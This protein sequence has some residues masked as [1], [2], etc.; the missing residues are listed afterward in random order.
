MAGYCSTP[1]AKKLGFK[2]PLT[3]YG[4]RLPSDYSAWLDGPEGVQFVG[5]LPSKVCA[6][7]EVWSGPKLVVR[8]ELR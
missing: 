3:V 6:V 1:L 8:R 7:S 2:A 5:R 4:V